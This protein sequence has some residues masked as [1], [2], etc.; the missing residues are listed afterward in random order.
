MEFFL[1]LMVNIFWIWK[2]F[3][4]SYRNYFKS[5]MEFIHFSMVWL[6]ITFFFMVWVSAPTHFEILFYY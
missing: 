6:L 4:I 5:Q 2:I 1:I 3:I